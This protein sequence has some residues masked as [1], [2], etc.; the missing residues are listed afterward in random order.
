MQGPNAFAMSGICSPV[1]HQHG[2]LL[3]HPPQFVG[4]RGRARRA[5]SKQAHAGELNQIVVIH[6]VHFPDRADSTCCSGGCSSAARLG[7]TPP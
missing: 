3:R 1:W 7:A 5:R 6:G 2:P 4:D